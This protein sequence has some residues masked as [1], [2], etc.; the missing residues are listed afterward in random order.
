MENQFQRTEIL[1]GEQAMKWLYSARVA[2][3]GVG[4]VGGYVVE[5]LARCG[6]GTF[7]FID[8]DEVCITNMNRQIIATHKT[9]GKKKV[10]VIKERVLEINPKAEIYTYPCF[11][12]PENSNQFSWME[13]DYIVDAVDTITAK[14]ELVMQ[15]K[16]HK[17]PIISSMGAG[18][19]LDPTRFK[20]ADIYE[21]SICPLA[22]VMRRELRKREIHDLKVVYST[23]EP[24]KPLKSEEVSSKREIPGSISFVPS[25]VGLIIASEVIKDLSIG[26]AQNDK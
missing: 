18:N 15:A 16:K 19:K 4:G 10:D 20:I 13:Y 21:T 5:A 17:I 9:L 26:V 6:I 24:I 1:L 11:F 8:N 22:K 14:I 2:I 12:L 3:F 25:A 7:D 23:E